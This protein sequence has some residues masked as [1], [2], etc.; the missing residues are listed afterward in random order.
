MQIFNIYD[1]VMKQIWLV[2][3]IYSGGS[4]PLE[5]LTLVNAQFNCDMAL[6]NFPFDIQNCKLMIGISDIMA[7]FVVWGNISVSYTGKV[8]ALFS[9]SCWVLIT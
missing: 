1:L 4:N 8:R 6:E 5:M 9:L 2:D 3:S 7:D